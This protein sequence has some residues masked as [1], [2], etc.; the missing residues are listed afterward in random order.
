MHLG[1]FT[2][3]VQRPSVI[4]TPDRTRALGRVLANSLAKRLTL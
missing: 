2:R 3:K 4:I 1:K